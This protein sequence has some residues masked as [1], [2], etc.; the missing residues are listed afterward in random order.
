MFQT[1]NLLPGFSARRVCQNGLTAH[2]LGTNGVVP[3]GCA[4]GRRMSAQRSALK[5]DQR[6]WEENR[7][8][9]S[10]AA[11]RTEVR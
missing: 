2:H 3:L 4:E 11:S 10:G 7:L 1:F 9:T 8:L 6:A 5:D